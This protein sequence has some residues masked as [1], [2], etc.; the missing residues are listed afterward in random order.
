M[1]DKV[2]LTP[3]KIG[4]VT[5]KNRVMFPSMCTFFCE[6]DGSVSGD[7]LAFVEDL[8]KGGTGLIVVPGSPHGKP[9]PGRPALSDDRYIPG[10]KSMADTAHRYG[11]RLFCQLHPAAVQAGRDKVVRAVVDYDREM[12]RQLVDSYAAEAVRCQKSGVDG[13]EIHGAHAHEIAQFMSPRYNERTDEYGGDYKMRYRDS[14]EIVKAN[15]EGWGFYFP[16]TFKIKGEQMVERGR[17][18]PET[19]P[20][21]W[22]VE[23]A[24]IVG[25]HVSM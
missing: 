7:Q 14:N 9:G 8:A 18:I 5:V 1:M 15:K 21:R 10:W 17:K 25:V 11:A 23:K 12:I 4:T 13:V 6:E 16:I 20:I 19:N 2:I 3:M 22:V 24:G